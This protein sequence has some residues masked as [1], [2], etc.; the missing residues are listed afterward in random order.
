ALEQLEHGG[1]C[2]HRLVVGGLHAA[3]LGPGLLEVLLA[4]DE[5]DAA[6]A[7]VQRDDPEPPARR[8]A[9]RDS[10]LGPTVERLAAL[11]VRPRGDVE[12][13]RL[14]VPGQDAAAAGSVDQVV[15]G[16]PARGLRPAAVAP[17]R[18]HRAPVRELDLLD[19]DALVDVDAE[20]ARVLEQQL[21][22]LVALDLP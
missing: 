2:T 13:A 19:A 20:A 5:P 14:E 9:D 10:A 11:P 7:V 4:G 22:E 16:D 18:R 12:P 8:G 1:A 3:G 21:V 6:R 15:E 17:L